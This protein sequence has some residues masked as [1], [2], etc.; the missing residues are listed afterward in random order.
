MNRAVLLLL[1]F[2]IVSATSVLS[3]HFYYGTFH[4]S[5]RDEFFF[6][7][8]FGQDTVE[9]AKLLIDKVKDYTN[10]FL[11]NNWNIVTNETALNEVCDYAVE[12]DLSFIVFFSWVSREIYPWHQTW[13]DTAKD[14]WGEHFLGVHL[15]DEPGGTQIDSG[16]WNEA[17]VQF[18]ENVSDYSEA[19]DLFVDS[20]SS[21]DSTLDLKKRDIPMFT[22]DYALYWFDYLAGYD[23]VFVELGWNHNSATH[24]GLCRGAA[25]AQGK[26]WGAIITWTYYEP[27]YLA[28][29]PEILEEMIAAYVAGA[30]YVVVFNYARDAETEEAFCILQEEHFAAMEEFWGYVQDHPERYGQ[31]RGRVAFVLPRDYGWGFRRLEDNVWGLWPADEKAPVIWERLHWLLDRYGLELD[32]VYDDSAFDYEDKYAQVYFWNDDLNQNIRSVCVQAGVL[33]T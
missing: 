29:G 9:E 10:F 30:K 11:V 15:F 2:L 16:G 27:P 22:S 31:M 14:R 6:G 28:S 3:A 20:I 13:L 8:S 32:I 23:T 18:F 12:A 26:D 21:I 1:I 17:M 4:A 24:I 7:V 25:N 19:A 33:I 5:A